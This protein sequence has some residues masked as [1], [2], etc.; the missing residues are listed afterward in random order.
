MLRCKEVLDD[1]LVSSVGD[2]YDMAL[3]YLHDWSIPLSLNDDRLKEML[4]SILLD[5][6]ACGETNKL[7]LANLAIGRIRE[8][9]EATERSSIFAR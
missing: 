5:L 1:K 4:A 6:A 2:A 8:M 9:A 3:A 7:R